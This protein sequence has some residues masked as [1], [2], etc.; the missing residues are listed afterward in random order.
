MKF[1]EIGCSNIKYH[2]LN[3][4]KYI[5]APANLT[6]FCN[7]QHPYKMKNKKEK[8]DGNTPDTPILVC[9]LSETKKSIGDK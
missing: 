6:E 5:A 8:P 2:K 9:A 3:K 4:E 7:R 1:Y